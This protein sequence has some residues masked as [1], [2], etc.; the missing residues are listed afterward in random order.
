MT[1]MHSQQIDLIFS[2][3]RLK[4]PLNTTL[5]KKWKKSFQRGVF[6][7]WS[8]WW[9]LNTKI[10][11]LLFTK[12]IKFSNTRSDWYCKRTEIKSTNSLSFNFSFKIPT[13]TKHSQFSDVLSLR[14]RS[15]RSN[16][17]ESKSKE[18]NTLLASKHMLM[19]SSLET[20]RSEPESSGKIS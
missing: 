2:W 10:V 4:N 15:F 17:W 14:D 6:R 12:L 9:I 20:V 1:Q 19:S 7:I 11:M 5:L 16:W 13:Q 3:K 18:S 8:D